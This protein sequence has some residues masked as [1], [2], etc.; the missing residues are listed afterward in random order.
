MSAL[1]CEQKQ[2]VGRWANNRVENSHLSF[3]R[4]ERAMLRLRQ[5]KALQKF[6]SVHVNVHNH[7]RSER[8]LIDRQTYKTRR[9][10]VLAE[11]QN[12]MA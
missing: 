4:R 11:W 2:E 9:S 5:M 10:A 12:L 7:F 1:N 6:A 8:H 3:R